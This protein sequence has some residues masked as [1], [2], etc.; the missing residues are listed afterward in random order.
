MG[1]ARSMD[2]YLAIVPGA[3]SGFGRHFAHLLSAP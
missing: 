2:E 1:L 3:I